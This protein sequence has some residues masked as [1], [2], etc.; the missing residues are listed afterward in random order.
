[1]MG[2]RSPT[3]RWL[4]RYIRSRV[5]SNGASGVPYQLVTGRQPDLSFMRVFRCPD[6]VHQ[7]KSQR[8]KHDDRA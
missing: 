2:Y 8:H 4:W 3:G 7:D 6:Y 5:C 1:M